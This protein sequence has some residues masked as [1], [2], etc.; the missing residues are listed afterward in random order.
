MIKGNFLDDIKKIEPL[1]LD[2][3]KHWD[4][5][6][7]ILEMKN[8]N[9]KQWKQMEWFGFYFQYLCEQRLKKIMQLQKPRYGKTSFDG[10]LSCAWDFKAHSA[11]DNN[12][13]A[14]DTEATQ[15]AINDYGTAGVIL[16]LGNITYNDEDRSFQKWHEELKGG[17]SQYEEQRIE[18]G[19][20]SRLRKMSFDLEKVVFIRVDNDTLQKCGSFQKGMRNSNGRPR[21]EK[22]LIKLDKLTTEIAKSISY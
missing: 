16:A 6:T 9:N 5:K 17:K 10:F 3:P 7:A 8:N 22:V 18:R 12:V 1:L 14:N 4:A 15:R 11:S 13:P 20:P 2:I 21:R 19:A